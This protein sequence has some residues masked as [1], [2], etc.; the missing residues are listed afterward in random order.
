MTHEEYTTQMKVPA[1]GW[2]RRN[3]NNTNGKS[4]KPLQNGPML[5]RN[6]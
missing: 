3:A 2:T 6:Y 5:S 1:P 4:F